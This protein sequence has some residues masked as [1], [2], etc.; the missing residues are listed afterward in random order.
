MVVYV[1]GI[2]PQMRTK[3][4]LDVIQTLDVLPTK[5]DRMHIVNVIKVMLVQALNANMV[6][7]NIWKFIHI[8]HKS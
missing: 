8:V 6:C 5:A 7:L 4:V 3:C 2:T 1:N